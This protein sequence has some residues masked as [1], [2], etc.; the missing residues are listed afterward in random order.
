MH[1]TGAMP[2]RARACTTTYRLAERKR[3]TGV[4]SVVGFVAGAE[5]ANAVHA[6]LRRGAELEGLE[7]RVHDALRG[8]CVAGADGGVGGWIQETA[9][10][11]DDVDRCE[12]ALVQGYVFADH[13]AEAVDDA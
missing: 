9:F 10:G 12:T 3:K 6:A 2:S 8:L 5:E 13:A 7:D 4:L 11:E 1:A